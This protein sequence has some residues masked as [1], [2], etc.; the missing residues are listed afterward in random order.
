[1]PQHERVVPG[2]VPGERFLQGAGLGAHLPAGQPGQLARVGLPGDQ[3]VEH[4]PAGGAEDVADHHRQLDLGVFEEFLGALLFP[5]PFL[6]QGAGSGSGPV[7]GA[8]G[9]TG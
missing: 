2:E 1:M 5:G 8:A 3:G 4:G 9:G 6:G 7:A